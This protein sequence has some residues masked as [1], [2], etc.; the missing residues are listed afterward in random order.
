VRVGLASEL[1]E[2][3]ECLYA[4]VSS[5][6]VEKGRECHCAR[7][8]F[9]SPARQRVLEHGRRKVVSPLKSV[10][11]VKAGGGWSFELSTEEAKNRCGRKIVWLMVCCLD[12]LWPS[13]ADPYRAIRR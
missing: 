13:V 2:Y 12:A 8:R 9:L 11:G 7:Q 1:P 5:S 6:L 3:E 10:G 4:Q